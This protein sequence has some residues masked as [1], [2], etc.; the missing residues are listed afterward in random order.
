MPKLEDECLERAIT[1][2]ASAKFIAVLVIDFFRCF[3]RVLFTRPWQRHPAFL[4]SHN[5]FNTHSISYVRLV[6]AADDAVRL[7]LLSSSPFK[8]ISETFQLL[9]HIHRFYLLSEYALHG[10]ERWNVS[11]VSLLA[12]LD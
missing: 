8:I 5:E 11:D 1:F 3:K 9:L 4:W 12:K 7:A 10:L 6:V 2:E